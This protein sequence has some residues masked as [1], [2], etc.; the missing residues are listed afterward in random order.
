M[1]PLASEHVY[2]LNRNTYRQRRT[3][4]RRVFAAAVVLGLL[5]FGI[6]EARSAGY[7][8]S[9]LDYSCVNALTAQPTTVYV[10]P[11][12]DRPVTIDMPVGPG[13]EAYPTYRGS[14]QE[15]YPSYTIDGSELNQYYDLYG[16]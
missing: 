12:Y 14:Y 7:C 2:E 4:G 3:R 15:R 16:E 8:A 11:R 6:N 13:I 1:N 9:A 10:A 5:A